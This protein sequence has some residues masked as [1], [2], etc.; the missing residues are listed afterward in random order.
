VQALSTGRGQQRMFRDCNKLQ[1]PGDSRSCR[2]FWN[3][4]RTRNRIWHGKFPEK[5][6]GVSET[7]ISGPGPDGQ[8][9]AKNYGK[10]PETDDPV[11]YR[12]SQAGNDPDFWDSNS[13]CGR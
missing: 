9:R 12:G 2:D 5:L 6:P 7:G 11:L 10:V 1:Q 8:D 13:S 3:S 4:R